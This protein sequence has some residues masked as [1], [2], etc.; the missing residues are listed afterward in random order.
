MD[1]GIYIHIPFCLHKCPYCDF[2]SIAVEPVPEESYVG[3]LIDEIK[4][5]AEAFKSYKVETIYLGGGTPSLF[6]PPSIASVLEEISRRFSLD[7]SAEITI[8]ANPKTVDRRKLSAFRSLG[9]NRVSLGV[10][11]F[12]DDCLMTLGRVHGG[13]DAMEAFEEARKAGFENIGID[14]IFGIP[15]QRLDDWRKDLDRAVALHP[16]HISTYQLQVEEGTPFF[17]RMAGG[18]LVLPSEELQTAMF[19]ITWERLEQA[20]YEHYE[21]SNF[22]LPGFRSR[23]NQRYWD[24]REYLGIGAAA[25][26]FLDIGWGKRRSNIADPL[27]YMAGGN[28][29][30][31]E[32]KLEKEEAME[33][34][35]FLGLRRREG[36]DLKRFEERFGLPV[37][38]R[39][40]SMEGLLEE[41]MGH[42][43]L[44]P[45][46]LL[47]MN[48]VSV[49]LMP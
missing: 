10:Q 3:A 1:I 14:L 37:A 27:R 15:S 32:E 7:G 5:R 39:S 48:E 44:T 26:S 42:L 18:E 47:L 16:E 33:E 46:G 24:L 38:H 17:R 12:R 43:R 29:T 31:Y 49:R 28:R 13:A 25:H 9:I 36:I 45:R 4:A 34:A 40:S 21:I 41:E 23:H 6:S 8:E 30:G 11:S 22:A 19:E 20:G 2:N 35:I